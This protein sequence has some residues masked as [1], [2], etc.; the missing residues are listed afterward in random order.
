MFDFPFNE[1]SILTSLYCI[2]MYS[3]C[4][5]YSYQLSKSWDIVTIRRFPS[6]SI[7]LFVCFIGFFF[8]TNC[9]NGDFFHTMEKV[10]DYHPSVFS[11]Y[12]GEP[13]YRVI[14]SFVNNNYLLF[15]IIVWGGAFAVYC[16]TARRM[17]IP[18]FMAV[19]IICVFYSVTFCYARVTAAMAVYFL[20]LS[21][22]CY[23]NTNKWLG[24]IIGGLLIYLSLQF[25]TSA[26]IMIV[27]T[28]ML[29][30]PIKKWSI[31]IMIIVIPIIA[32]Y[33]KDYFFLFALDE[34]TDEFISNKMLNYSERVVVTGI[35]SRIINILRYASIYIPLFY[36]Y[37]MIIRKTDKTHEDQS[38][39]RL[40]KV[41]FGLAYV[42]ITFLFFGET[43]YTFFYRILNMTIIPIALLL[44][45]LYIDKRM[46]KRQFFNCL[47][48]GMLSQIVSYSYMIYLNR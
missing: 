1:P 2:L 22:F 37:R 35:A 25:H 31:A 6:S 10:H 38:M 24:Y 44:S 40:F 21:Y 32:V 41:T 45:K 43:F 8:V 28:V 20:G 39:L 9:M 33:F 4:V 23:P 13:I 36:C 29:F 42:S 26:L 3:I 48:L 11:Y 5:L 47:I 30:M 18:L 7:L 19:S 17:K 12:N 16:I 34:D 15:R 27:M 46:S 14:T